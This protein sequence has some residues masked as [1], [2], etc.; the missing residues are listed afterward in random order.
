MKDKDLLRIR[1]LEE[2]LRPFRRVVK[3]SSPHGGWIRAIREALGMT[4]VQLAKLTDRA[5]Q[6][7]E[8]IQKSEAN[9]T[10]QL[11]TLREVAE[12]LGCKV[13]Y[14]VVPAKPLTEIMRERAREK[15]RARLRAISHSMKLE[16]QGVGPKEEARQ[17]E[18]LTQRL[19]AGSPKKLW[20]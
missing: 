17:L 16:D 5:P 18:I 1:Q 7:I 11:N 10:I 8:D 4:N 2:T 3:A 15:A 13:V 19:L 20:E 9:G 6:T 12:A 14:A